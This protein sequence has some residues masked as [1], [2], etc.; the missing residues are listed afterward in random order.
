MA[1]TLTITAIFKS[2]HGEK[3]MVNKLNGKHLLLQEMHP[4]NEIMEKQQEKITAH[5]WISP[6]APLG[7]WQYFAG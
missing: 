7:T 1:P 5:K 3:N 2:L 4:I 6:L